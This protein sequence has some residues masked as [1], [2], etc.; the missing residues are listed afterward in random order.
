M[1]KEKRRNLKINKRKNRNKN[2]MIKKNNS[3]GTRNLFHIPLDIL[4]KCI[5]LSKKVN[6]SHGEI[7]M[8]DDCMITVI[9]VGKKKHYSIHMK[10][11]ITTRFS[12]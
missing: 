1:T 12:L 8:W 5:N 2:R 6:H 11:G 10:D 4:S 7:H 9:P 3:N